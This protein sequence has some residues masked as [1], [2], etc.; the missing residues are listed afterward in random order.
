MNKYIKKKY[1]SYLQRGLYTRKSKTKFT[2]QDF[3]DL[4][5]PKKWQQKITIT[6]YK[7]N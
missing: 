7:N 5:L 4:Y 3:I 1:T 2:T 6:T